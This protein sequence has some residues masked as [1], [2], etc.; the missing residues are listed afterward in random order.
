[1]R[2]RIP[3]TTVLALLA[4]GLL[5]SDCEESSPVAPARDLDVGLYDHGAHQ[6][7]YRGHPAGTHSWN[8]RSQLVY[9]EMTAPVTLTANV[10]YEVDN[11]AVGDACIFLEAGAFDPPAYCLERSP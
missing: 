11:E 10:R 4:L 2:R 5:G 3:Q 7:D 9:I 6:Q 1:M 8:G